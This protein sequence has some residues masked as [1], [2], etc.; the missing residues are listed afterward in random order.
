MW[1]TFEK[2]GQPG[3]GA[4]IP[5]LNLFYLIEIADR[6]TWW[7]VLPFIPV[8]GWLVLLALFV[9]IGK[10]FGKGA[11]TGLGLAF[12]PFLFWPILGFGGATYHGDTSPGV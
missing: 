9:D 7:I 4:F 2:A 6:P 1:K 11:G 3:W 8:I 12:L 5:L 10:Q